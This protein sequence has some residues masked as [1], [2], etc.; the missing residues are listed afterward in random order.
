MEAVCNVNGTETEKNSNIYH[1]RTGDTEFQA[2]KQKM[3]IPHLIDAIKRSPDDTEAGNSYSVHVAKG[4]SDI[5]STSGIKIS[6]VYS[7][8][9][10]SEVSKNAQQSKPGSRKMFFDVINEQNETKKSDIPVNEKDLN[11]GIAQPFLKN[12]YKIYKSKSMDKLNEVSNTS[13]NEYETENQ[14]LSSVS[15]NISQSNNINN[16]YSNEKKNPPFINN[17]HNLNTSEVH[18]DGENRANLVSINRNGFEFYG[19]HTPVNQNLI[20]RNILHEDIETG[21]SEMG[22]E[23][24][25]NF[26]RYDSND[27]NGISHKSIEFVPKK[28]LDHQRHFDTQSYNSRFTNIHNLRNMSSSKHLSP[29]FKR[30]KNWSRLETTVLLKELCRIIKKQGNQKREYILRSNKTFE[31]LSRDLKRRGYNRD[32]QSCLVR[33]RNVLRIYKT[34]RRSILEDGADISNYPFSYE[35]E[36]IYNCR[37][38]SDIKSRSVEEFDTAESSARDK[39]NL[40]KFEKA[41]EIG[42]LGD[43]KIEN[44][45]KRK[46]NEN[47]SS[48]KKRSSTSNENNYLTNIEENKKFQILNQRYNPSKFPIAF[49]NNSININPKDGQQAESFFN[50]N[51]FNYGNKS[52]ESVNREFVS[53]LEHKNGNNITNC[54][55]KSKFLFGSSFESHVSNRNPTFSQEDRNDIKFNNESRKN[56]SILS[57]IDDICDESNKADRFLQEYLHIQK[58]AMLALIEIKKSVSKNS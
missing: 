26:E 43:I 13:D 18:S 25:F 46:Y 31:D 8:E 29:K 19:S 4:S 37:D 17:A 23:G 32:A 50:N 34:E 48:P 16:E 28:Y 53:G 39:N 45:S 9:P 42:S 11:K 7:L 58:K 15:R 12:G 14:P 36:D 49:L 54:E 52:L 57:L 38:S 20:S 33:W 22:E 55:Q 6:K 56:Q 1:V 40:A 21:E 44:Q 24:D 47:D 30:S 41:R 35:I 27:A 5:E 51:T 2:V 10:S 3:N